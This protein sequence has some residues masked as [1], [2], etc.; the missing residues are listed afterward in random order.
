MEKTNFFS[1]ETNRLYQLYPTKTIP[2]L[3]I[4]AVPMHRYTHTD[5]LTDAIL[6]VRTVKPFGIVLDICTGLGYSAIQIAKL[7]KVEKVITIENDVNVLEVAKLNPASK[8]LF[9]NPKIKIINED[10]SEEIKDFPDNHFDSILHDPPTF[11]L[12]SELYNVNFYRQLFRVLKKNCKL[13]HYCAEPGKRTGKKPLKDRIIRD[14]KLAGFR[15][16]VYD[17]KSAG[18]ICQ[19]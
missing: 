3:K 10:A 18:I 1:K 16:I 7:D 4:S 13:W 2:A 8:E 12:A 6:K 9:D 19:K 15:N 14:L 11:S 17:E 5:P